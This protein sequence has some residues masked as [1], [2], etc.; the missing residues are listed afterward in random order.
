[1]AVDALLPAIAARDL[2][3]G[4]GGEAVGEHVRE[5]GVPLARIG[6]PRHIGDLRRR[7]VGDEH[8]ALHRKGGLAGSG[9]HLVEGFKSEEVCR[10]RELVLPPEGR[11]LGGLGQLDPLNGK[12]P[13]M[14]AQERISHLLVMDTQ[15]PRNRSPVVQR[16]DGRLPE[17]GEGAVGDVS[18][19]HAMKTCAVCP[20]APSSTPSMS[21]AIIACFVVVSVQLPVPLGALVA[22]V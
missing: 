7:G 11:S 10:K 6:D 3:A 2:E 17:E 4:C 12:V 21:K 13:R 19:G 15:R 5:K 16:Q 14:R 8:P 1:M 22:P 18:L 9:L 20:P